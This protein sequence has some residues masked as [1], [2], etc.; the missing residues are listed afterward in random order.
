LGGQGGTFELNTMLPLIAYNLLHSINLLHAAVQRF[1][2]KCV[3]GI[4]ANPEKCRQNIEQSLAMAT[5][6]NSAVGYEKAAAIAQQAYKEGKTIRE[7]ALA[8]K[9]IPQDEIN[10]LLDEAIG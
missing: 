3:K 1:T 7:T 5:A 8:E 9:D 2:L 6:L 4:T 10:R